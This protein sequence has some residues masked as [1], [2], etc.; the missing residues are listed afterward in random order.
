MEHYR[1]VASRG[2]SKGMSFNLNFF[3]YLN[4]IIQ[5]LDSL[6]RR[7]LLDS[8]AIYGERCHLSP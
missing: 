2:F 6:L 4:V 1:C 8:H 7:H 5:K 3:S